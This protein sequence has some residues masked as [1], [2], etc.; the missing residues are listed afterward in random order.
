MQKRGFPSCTAVLREAIAKSG[1]RWR[2]ARV[3]LTSS[4][5]QY[6]EKLDR[7]QDV[8]SKARSL[9]VAR[10]SFEKVTVRV[11]RIACAFA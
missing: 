7:L 11:S 5:P 4:D 2:A 9:V 3:V 6:Q 10:S 8:L 1:F